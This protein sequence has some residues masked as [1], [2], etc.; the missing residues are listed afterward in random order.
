MEQDQVHFLRKTSILVKKKK[1]ATITASEK[2][3]MKRQRI[4]LRGVNNEEGD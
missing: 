4:V 2:H 1:K 3:A